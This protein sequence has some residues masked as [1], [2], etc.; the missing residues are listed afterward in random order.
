MLN[1][2]IF[3]FNKDGFTM[4]NYFQTKYDQIVQA[5]IKK[6]CTMVLKNNASTMY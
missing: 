4:R 3:K 2:V 5:H 1:V 6:K